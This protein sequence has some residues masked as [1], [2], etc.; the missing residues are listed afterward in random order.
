MYEEERQQLVGMTRPA[1][2][3]RGMQAFS[4]SR[5][6]IVSPRDKIA[7]EE[8]YENMARGRVHEKGSV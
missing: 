1:E 6:V 8:Q 2:M 3:E 7:R 4:W 5:N